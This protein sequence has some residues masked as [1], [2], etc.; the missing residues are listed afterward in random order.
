MNEIS[1]YL[2]DFVTA[3]RMEINEDAVKSTAEVQKCF[4]RRCNCSVK[5][6]TSLLDSNQQEFIVI[7]TFFARP[8]GNNNLTLLV[9][10]KECVRI[11][12]IDTK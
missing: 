10:Q 12:T 3:T 2:S 9:F 11:A 4:S 5:G 8:D 1:L 7:L 6:W